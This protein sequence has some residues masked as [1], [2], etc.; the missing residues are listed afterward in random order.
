MNYR[1][2]ALI[3]ADIMIDFKSKFKRQIEILGI[4]LSKSYKGKS[5]SDLAAIFGV[6]ELTIKRDLNDLRTSGITIHSAK[7]TGVVIDKKPPPDKI[8]E[9]IRQYSA[10]NTSDSFVEKS[11]AMLVNRLKEDALANMVTLQMCIDKNKMAV[12]DY[13]KDADVYEN[14]VEISPLLIFQ[15]D[16]YWRLLTITEGGIKQFIMNKIITAR[17]SNRR[18]KPV[19][20]EKIDDVF[21][22][23][24]RSWLGEDTYRIKLEF[25]AYWSDRI[26]PKQLL[27]SEK[28]TV[29]PGGSVIYEATVN[30]LEEIAGWVVTRG[31]G[32]KALEPPELKEK[33]IALANGVLKNYKK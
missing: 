32:V 31:E 14:S 23:S 22:H 9:F 1:K 10:L 33:V 17:E 20:R 15:T 18:F 21:K 3:L 30:S 5:L 7:G 29:Q 24:F 6:E 12:I 11:T 4:C 25:S 27:D 28:F 13:E 26:K 8:R 19:S 2:I 16:N